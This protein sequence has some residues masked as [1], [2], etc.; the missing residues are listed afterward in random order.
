M[1]TREGMAQVSIN[2]PEAL[3]SEYKDVLKSRIPRSNTTRDVIQH[4]VDVVNGARE[5]RGEKPFSED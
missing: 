5:K 2:V 3:Y 1:S 4:M